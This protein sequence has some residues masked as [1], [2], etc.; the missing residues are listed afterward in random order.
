MTL[1]LLEHLGGNLRILV[2]AP[3]KPSQKFKHL[4]RDLLPLDLETDDA[5]IGNLSNSIRDASPLLRG[6]REPT[7]HPPQ[8]RAALLI[9]VVDEAHGSQT[10]RNR[11][12]G[13]VLVLES[14]GEEEVL[15]RR[16]STN[17]VRGTLEGGAGLDRGLVILGALGTHEDLAP[18]LPRG[19]ELLTRNAPAMRLDTVAVALVLVGETNGET[20]RL[21][22]VVTIETE[23]LI[24]D[25]PLI[26]DGMVE[27]VKRVQEGRLA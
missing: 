11:S 7:H 4:P 9:T 15:G 10:A 27:A 18:A 19:P 1:E 6:V 14:D 13:G 3:R 20:G 16:D 26:T 24:Q 22:R 17:L 8:T 5:K 23:G 12:K 2:F 21:R 25:V